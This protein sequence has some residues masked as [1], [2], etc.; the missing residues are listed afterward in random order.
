MATAANNQLYPF[1]DA[2][3]KAIP[4]DIVLPLGALLVPVAMDAMTLVTIPAGYVT[5]SIFCDIDI[6]LDFTATKVYPVAGDV[7]SGL[8]VHKDT[9]ISALL[10]TTGVVRAVPLVAA[11]AGLLRIQQVQKWA[12]L[13]LARQLVRR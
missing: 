6:L 4:L 7:T 2:D 5:V 3:G 10:P 9:V 8:I 11:Q 1:S 13:G 12:G